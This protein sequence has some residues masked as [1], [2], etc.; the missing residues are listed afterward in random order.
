MKPIVTLDQAKKVRALRD[1][2]VSWSAITERFGHSLR[3]LL[4]AVRRLET[5]E[6]AQA[7][8]QPSRDAA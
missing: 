3:A 2:G 1:Q 6:A 5:V 8:P 4:A 7:A